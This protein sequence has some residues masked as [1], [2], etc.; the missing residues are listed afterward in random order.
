MTTSH[1]MY[2]AFL[3]MPT[4]LR[5][6]IYDYVL[7]DTYSVTISAGYTTVFG[8]RIKD[9]ARKQIS[10]LPFELAPIARRHYDA[11][12]LSIAK[13]PEIAIDND[14][15]ASVEQAP[16]SL[17]MPTPVALQL[18]CHQVKDEL[19]STLR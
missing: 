6:Q 15:L 3:S 12:L 7:A 19:K 13:P 8:Q 2:S 14:A 5:C 10:G 18:C 16:E 1:D 9:R 4:E 11:S 17:G